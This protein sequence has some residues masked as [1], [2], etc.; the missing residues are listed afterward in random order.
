MAFAKSTS[1]NVIALFIGFD[2]ESIHKMEEKWER[3]GAPC[4]LVTIK[5]EYR[6]LLGPLSRF[7]RR[8]EFW[9]GGKPDHIQ[10]LI[11]QFVPRKWWHHLLHNQTSFLLRMWMIR[12]KDVV[13]T[14]VPYHLHK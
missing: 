8:L 12:H 9:E 3:W 5:S 11:A 7:V 1:Q 14:T 4:R 10:I 13:V 2:D 6:S